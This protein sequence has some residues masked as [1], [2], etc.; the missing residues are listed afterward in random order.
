MKPDITLITTLYNYSKYIS[1]CIKSFQQQTLKNTEMIIIDDASKDN[2]MKI[3]KPFLKD[4]RIKYIRLDENGGYSKAK[5]IGIKLAKSEI[6]VMLDA[7]DK[8][9]SKS[10][11]TRYN[12]M[13]DKGYDFVHGPVYDL[14]N[15][16]KQMSRLWPLWLRDHC[17]KH[18]HAQGVMLKKDIHRKIGLYDETMKCKSDREMWARIFN[19][20]FKIGYVKKPVAIYRIHRAQM[21]R[22][23]EKLKINDRLQRKALKK[24]KRR[25]KDLSGLE[26]LK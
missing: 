17:Y 24:I 12:R 3:I 5:N 25:K 8:L 20:K 26:M 14:R 22:S 4:D 9:T 7:D 13:M 16:R 11:Q 23:P 2:P 1:D 18:V 21:S 6:L 10:F 15:N 19:H